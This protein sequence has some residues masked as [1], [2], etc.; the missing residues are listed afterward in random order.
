MLHNRPIVV[1][2]VEVQ[3]LARAT[4]IE[5]R[6]A[7]Y[8]FAGLG[9]ALI[10]SLGFAPA[11]AAEIYG[12]VTLSDGRTPVANKPISLA[13]K[14]IGRTDPAGAYRLSLP[15]GQYTLTIEGKP[16]AISVPPPGVKFDIRVQ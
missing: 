15:P 5:S 10:F 14:Q 16:I 1:S 6:W 11:Q 12:R 2:D 9:L 4:P 7:S 13:G 8:R 3:M